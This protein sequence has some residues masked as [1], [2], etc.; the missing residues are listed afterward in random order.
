M[1][2][3]NYTSANKTKKKEKI[4][5][6]YRTSQSV[7]KLNFEVN[8]YEKE[9]HA[10][11]S[12]HDQCVDKSLYSLTGSNYL[13]SLIHFLLYVELSIS[14]SKYLIT[15]FMTSAIKSLK[16]VKFL[17][18]LQVCWYTNDMKIYYRWSVKI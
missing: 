14:I 3:R 10:E 1:V 4:I 7:G 9:R 13:K 6:T 17:T 8:I 11:P 16:T 12:G 18:F 15:E 5:L 2:E